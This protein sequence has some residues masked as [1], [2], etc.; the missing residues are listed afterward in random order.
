MI[1]RTGLSVFPCAR[2]VYAVRCAAAGADRDGRHR[3]GGALVAGAGAVYSGGAGGDPAHA[4]VL[5]AQGVI[6]RIV[7]LNLVL[8]GA[9]NFWLPRPL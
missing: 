7:G 1:F 8:D 3:F 9:L 2:T 5:T 4:D 6:L